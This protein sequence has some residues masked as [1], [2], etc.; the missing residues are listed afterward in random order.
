MKRVVMAI[1]VLAAFAS[2]AYARFPRG[3]PPAV[4]GCDGS[5]NL[6]SGC[7]QPMLFH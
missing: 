7:V 3:A 6:S 4:V 1:A 2:V 5:I